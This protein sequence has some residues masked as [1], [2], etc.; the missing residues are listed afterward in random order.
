MTYFR[1]FFQANLVIHQIMGYSVGV[2]SGLK[3][4]VILPCV[5]LIVA[6][7]SLAWW[8]YLTGSRAVVRDLITRTTEDTVRSVTSD[9]VSFLEIPATVAR[10]NAAHFS[11]ASP[12]GSTS[13][14]WTIPRVFLD[15]LRAYPT[16]AILAVGFSD[17]EYREAQ[18]MD[19]GGFRFGRAGEV[20][21]GA[22]EFFQL[23][24]DEPSVPMESIP[25]FDPRERP[26]YRGARDRGTPMWSGVY[27]LYSDAQPAVSAAVPF[28]AAHTSGV[29]T[30]VVMLGGLSTYLESMMDP[31]KGTVVIIDAEEAMIAS[32]QGLTS[33]VDHEGSRRSLRDHPEPLF[34]RVGTEAEA[35]NAGLSFTLD[36]EQYTGMIK[37]LGHEFSPDWTVAVILRERAFTAPLVSA[38]RRTVGVMALSLLLSFGVGLAIVR[39]ILRPV[40]ALQR[41]VVRTDP[42]DPDDTETLVGLV[43]T[44]NEIGRLAAIF[45]ALTRRVQEDN[46]HLRASLHE[47]EVLLREVHHRVKN[48]LQ[49]VSSILNLETSANDKQIGRERLLRCQDRIQAMA[50]V[51]ENAYHTGRVSEI[52]VQEYLERISHSLQYDP[53]GGGRDT[54]ITVR[55]A[56]SVLPVEVAIP[57]GLIVNELVTNSLRHAFSERT[58]S[59]QIEVSL[60]WRGAFYRLSVQDNGRGPLAGSAPGEGDETGTATG[61]GTELVRA[62]S[63]Q[64]RGE[65]EHSNSDGY[66]VS[67][68]FPAPG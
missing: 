3:R 11:A 34:R 5:L 46:R 25:E 45:L 19:A 7:F 13:G 35:G 22:L 20:T 51:H 47:K 58:G 4:L 59:K 61:I 14:D 64:L 15:Q 44:R 42:T 48:N 38:D 28:D 37:E 6:V 1:W 49:I 24:A 39:S 63:A 18:R 67:I 60:D 2:S 54:V 9:I 31:G 62:L 17:G 52:E 50:Y 68:R 33:V 43:D 55:C 32:S 57:C 12:S 21:A 16:L 65:L 30:A 29:T 41:A 53:A 36:G 10:S 23:H 40:R 8:L 56:V 27:G 26:W 66:R